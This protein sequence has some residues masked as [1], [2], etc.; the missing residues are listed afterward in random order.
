MTECPRIF[1]AQ[2]R[3]VKV[4]AG[5]RCAIPTCRHPRVEIA[6]IIPY[7]QCKEHKFENLIVLCSNCHDLYDKDKRIDCKSML[8]YKHNLGLLSS[9]YD[10]FER[11]I[12]QFFC[13]FL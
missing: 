8:A 10:E 3:A 6:H 4:E 1:V 11:R 12:L 2:E 9:R 5:H 13:E 7:S